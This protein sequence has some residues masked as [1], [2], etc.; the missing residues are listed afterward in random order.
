[1]DFAEREET[2]G[3]A[4]VP[5][6]A[7]AEGED[8]ATPQKAPSG[9]PSREETAPGEDRPPDEEGSPDDADPPG[10]DRPGDDG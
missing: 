2:P 4:E 3:W 10:A 1:M 5:H 8:V 6:D 7:P 9:F